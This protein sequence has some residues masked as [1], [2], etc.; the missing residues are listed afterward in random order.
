[1]TPLSLGAGAAS[2]SRA[3]EIDLG[4]VSAFQSVQASLLP[5][6]DGL[7][8]GGDGIRCEGRRVFGARGGK[9]A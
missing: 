6:D 8:F 5:F 2:V 9:L 1:M 4:K 3:L 7:L